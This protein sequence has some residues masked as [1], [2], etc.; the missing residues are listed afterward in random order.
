MVFFQIFVI[1]IS[2]QAILCSFTPSPPGA[3]TTCHV[4]L[5]L[6][7]CFYFN[8]KI[9]EFFEFFCN[10]KHY[11]SQTHKLGIR[12]AEAPVGDLRWKPPVPLTNNTNHLL[13]CAQGKKFAA[14]CPQNGNRNDPWLQ[15]MSEDCLFLNV[16]TPSGNNI[17]CC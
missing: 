11:F 14:T 6:L 2:I 5:L 12:Y 9:E 7:L 15:D 16:F 13:G 17:F 8:S 1:S 3:A 4:I 10:F